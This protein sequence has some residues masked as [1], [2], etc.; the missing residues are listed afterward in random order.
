MPDKV[1]LKSVGWWLLGAFLVMCLQDA[2]PNG[3]ALTIILIWSA[4]MF[5]RV[6]EAQRP[7]RR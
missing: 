2:L 6:Y 1:V 7:P 3:W 4:I 5:V